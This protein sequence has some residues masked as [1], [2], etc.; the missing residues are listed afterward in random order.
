[1]SDVEVLLDGIPALTLSR[2]ADLSW[3]E[4]ADGGCET[5]SWAMPDLPVDFAPPELSN[6]PQVD[7]RLN[8][9]ILWTGYLSEPDYAAGTCNALGLYSLAD[10]AVAL[11][12]VNEVTSVPSVAIT[13]AMDRGVLDG[14][15][16][17]GGASGFPY[18]S[19]ATTEA[20]NYVRPLL[21][22]SA[23]AAGERAGV[24]PGGLYYQR[25]DPT[26]PAWLLT[27]G[28]G[29]MGVDDSDY[30]TNIYGRR[31]SAVGPTAYANVSTGLSTG[32][33]RR[34]RERLAD[35]TSLGL[36]SGTKAQ[37]EIDAQL[38]RDGLRRGYTNGID[39]TPLTLSTM[40]GTPA[41]TRLV[42]AGDMVRLHGLLD[43]RGSLNFAAYVD[44]VIDRV[45]H[46]AGSDVVQITPVGMADRTFGQII[47][48][49]ATTTD[50]FV[51]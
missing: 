45:Q 4:K 26:E 14:W 36:I 23:A 25:E 40:D 49:A 10:Q 27:P 1:M 17:Q 18:S 37:D 44:F 41:D 46:E 6:E 20:I 34:R 39:A 38:A 29:V 8:G 19:T 35:L 30:V 11:D 7:L 22:A 51:G 2:V 32:T 16:Y 5:A 28:A 21:E 15:R 12:S 47:T 42:H 9:H 33:T 48:K 31:V 13:E 3:S 50:V 43:A 24:G